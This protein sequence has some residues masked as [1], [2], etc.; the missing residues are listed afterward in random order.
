MK[1]SS[2]GKGQGKCGFYAYG[3]G[4]Y[5]KSADHKPKAS[6]GKTAAK[7]FEHR[8]CTDCVR[9]TQSSK[10]SSNL[11]PGRNCSSFEIGLSELWNK[12]L[13]ESMHNSLGESESVNTGSITENEFERARREQC[14]RGPGPSGGL[15]IPALKLKLTS[16]C[17]NE[18]HK[19]WII[20][21]DGSQELSGF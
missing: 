5:P 19:H 11:R 4:K 9:K 6:V 16:S 1:E 20:D 18:C 13:R 10:N 8:L 12:H 2:K 15:V 7:N 17:E 21:T 14:S 3:R